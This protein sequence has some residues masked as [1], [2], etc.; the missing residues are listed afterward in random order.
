M[1]SYITK[2]SCSRQ[3]IFEVKDDKLTDVRFVNGCNGNLK[4]I[5]KLCIGR[6]IDDIISDLKGIQCRNNTSCPDQLAVALEEYKSK[7]A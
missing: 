5:S 6:N 1:E 7:K 4:A 2:G 3:I